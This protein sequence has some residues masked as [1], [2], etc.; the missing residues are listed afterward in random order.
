MKVTLFL[1]KTIDQNASYYFEKAKKARRKRDGALETVERAKKKLIIVQAEKPEQEKKV[2]RKK[3]W[4]EKFHWFFSSEGF[5]CIG[6]RDAATN[7]II[8]KKHT[9]PHDLA[10]H[11]TMAGSP[12]F[13][14]KSDGK[15]IGKSTIEEC[16][17]ATG[18]YSRAWKLGVA[19]ADVF[20]VKPEQVSKTA[21]SGEYLP[22]GSFMIRGQSTIL[23]V[24]LRAAI[25]M[26]KDGVV[27]GGPVSAVLA[28]SEKSVVVTQGD[29][30][31]SDVAKKIKSRIGGGE[32]DEIIRFLPGKG[33]V[34]K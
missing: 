1:D 28:H 15:D 20:Y 17:Q 34:E 27:I 26:R 23:H 10:F 5:L 2:L 12:F 16:A 18:V 19:T 11:T 25:G 24:A 4:F 30:K 6:G 9:E 21:E 22:R 8:M 29:M 13:V 32:I 7:D 3:E 31:M 14:I 33:K